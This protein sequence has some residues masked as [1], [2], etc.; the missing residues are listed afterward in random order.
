MILLHVRQCKSLVCSWGVFFWWLFQG[1]GYVYGTD[2]PG[3]ECCCPG[4]LDPNPFH[5]RQQAAHNQAE[6]LVVYREV[7]DPLPGLRLHLH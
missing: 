2:L 6:G 1:F 7:V 3:F 5:F 4:S